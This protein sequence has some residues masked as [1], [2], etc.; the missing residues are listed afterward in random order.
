MCLLALLFRV[1]VQSNI[2]ALK[3]LRRDRSERIG[4][5]ANGWLLAIRGDGSMQDFLVTCITLAEQVLGAG[6]QAWRGHMGQILPLFHYGH[7][8]G[9]RGGGGA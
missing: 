5:V 7:E 9:E 6:R 1:C 8:E 3:E 4:A 2:Q